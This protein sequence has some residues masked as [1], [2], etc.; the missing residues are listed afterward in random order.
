MQ[1][2]QPVDLTRLVNQQ[3]ALR[4]STWS[5]HAGAGNTI[6]RTPLKLLLK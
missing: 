4:N 5:V 6:T 1:E 3:Q 2:S